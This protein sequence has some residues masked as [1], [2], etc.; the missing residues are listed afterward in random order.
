V[1]ELLF[2]ASDLIAQTRGGFIVFADDGFLHLAAG[3]VEAATELTGGQGTCGSAADV[4]SFVLHL[5]Q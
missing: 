5:K 3:V 4:G 2:E 1:R